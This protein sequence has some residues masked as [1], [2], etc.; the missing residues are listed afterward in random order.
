[1][2]DPN[3]LAQTTTTR[4]PRIF[5]NASGAAEHL[6]KLADSVDEFAHRSGGIARIRGLRG[7]QHEHDAAI[8]KQMADLGWLGILI[9]AHYGGLGLGLSEMAIVAEG[10]SRMLAPEPYNAVV[11][12]ATTVILESDN[13]VIKSEQLPHIA[14]GDILPVLAWQEEAG[15][16][17]SAVVASTAVAVDNGYRIS[18]CKKSIAGAAQADAFLV[19]ARDGSDLMLFWIPRECKGVLLQSETLADGRLFGTLTVQDAWIPA[20]QRI[21]HGATAVAALA[22]GLDF[23]TVV[24]SAE[25]CGVMDRVLEITLDYMKTRVQFGKPIG[26]FQALQHRAVDLYMHSQFSNAVLEEAA[27][28]IS[29]N[30]DATARA[31][32]ASR[33]KARCSDAALRIARESIQIHGAMGFTDECDIGLYMKRALVLAAWLGNATHHRRRYAQLTIAAAA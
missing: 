10:L 29:P 31:L 4:V 21:A 28:T 12:L 20:P 11:A 16:L 25:L 17:D 33:V 2:P 5:A 3:R 6:T 27:Q 8:W 32:L 24:A 9:P 1:M 19:S 26:S 18:G 23:A 15:N 30:T 22:T 14:S 7:T 13:E